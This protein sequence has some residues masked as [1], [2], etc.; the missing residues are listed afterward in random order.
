MSA[1][2]DGGAQNRR[3]EYQDGG[4]PKHQHGH[5][6]SRS[7]TWPRS[8]RIMAGPSAA[9][10]D[11]GSVE[12][13]KIGSRIIN[14]IKLRRSSRSKRYP[15]GTPCQVVNERPRGRHV[16]ATASRNMEVQA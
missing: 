3:Q 5:V 14:A 7:A 6:T 2:Q 13:A 16:R 8:G 10:A 15:H 1:E 12:W 11:I 4:D 9:S